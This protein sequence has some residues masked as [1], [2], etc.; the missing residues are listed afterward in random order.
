MRLFFIPLVIKKSRSSFSTKHC[1]YSKYSDK[2]ALAISV[3]QYQTPQNGASD[4]GLHCLP[5]NHYVLDTPADKNGKDLR[6][7][8]I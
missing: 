6:Y 1:V 3:D 8:T 5:H 2:Q 7:P 4:L